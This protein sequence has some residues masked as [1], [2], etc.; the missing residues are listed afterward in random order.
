MTDAAF[1]FRGCY[2]RRCACPRQARTRALARSGPGRP[3]AL[4]RHATLT[5][6]GVARRTAQAPPVPADPQR[7]QE[8]D[9]FPEPPSATSIY[10]VTNDVPVREQSAHVIEQRGLPESF[11]RGTVFLHIGHNSL[12]TAITDE[13]GELAWHNPIAEAVFSMTYKISL[14]NQQRCRRPSRRDGYMSQLGL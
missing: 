4:A 11:Y 9:L 14:P 7:R 3:G 10:T 12:L 2:R 8:L 5:K 6:G 13:F 1:L